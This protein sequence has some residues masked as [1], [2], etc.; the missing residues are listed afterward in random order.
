MLEI[1]G[2]VVAQGWCGIATA[3]TTYD[4]IRQFAGELARFNNSLAGEANLEAG[5]DDIGL[6]AMRFYTTDAA[7]HVACAVRLATPASGSRNDKI[8][9][10][11]TEVRTEPSY[12]E[13]LI[14]GL[15]IIAAEQ[16]GE[17]MLVIE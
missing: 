7:R 6:V 13:G 17:A 10:L 4:E 2:K 15:E 3:Y 14:K 11:A 9:K 8:H 16:A 5:R 12:I 1:E